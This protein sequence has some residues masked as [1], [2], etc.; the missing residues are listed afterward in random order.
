MTHTSQEALQ[1]MNI[2]DRRV[3]THN[4]RTFF[5]GPIH[6]TDCSK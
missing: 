3:K 6:L 4:F 2:T 5:Y 1:D